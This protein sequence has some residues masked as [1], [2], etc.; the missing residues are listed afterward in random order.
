MLVVYP[1][2]WCKQQQ[3]STQQQ[4]VYKQLVATDALIEKE[5]RFD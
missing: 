5:T 2:Q 1:R 4:L 3:L